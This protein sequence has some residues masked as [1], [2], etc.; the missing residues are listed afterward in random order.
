MA[1]SDTLDPYS[2]PNVPYQPFPVNPL[3]TGDIQKMQQSDIIKN[4]N[5]SL[6]ITSIVGGFIVLIIILIMWL[7]DKKLVNRV[8]LR[9]SGLISFVD[10]LSG[11]AAIAY[12]LYTT[13][14]TSI[15][16]FIG[17]AMSF[18]PT[19][20]LFLTV[21]IAFNLQ[22]VFLH[23]KKVSAFSDRWYLPVA[24]FG[25]FAINVPPL[26]Y[27]I[28]GYDYEGKEC[29]YRDPNGDATQMWK[30]ITFIIPVSLSMLY[31]TSVLIVVIMKLIFEHRKLADAVHTQKS[32]ATLTA[33][34]RRQKLLLL[35]L[36]S[37]ISLY[38]A[39]PLLNVSGIIVEYTW[40]SIHKTL[41]VPPPLV[42]WA[43]IGSCLPGLFNC[44]AFLFDPAIHNALRKVKKDLIENYGY[45]RHGLT[46]SQIS[47]PLSP[48][49][50]PTPTSPLFNPPPSPTFLRGP[51]RP[52]PTSPRS[53][54]MRILIP[55]YSPNRSAISPL[56]S[57][58]SPLRSQ[59]D[60]NV[61][62]TKM[63]PNRPILRWFVRAFLDKQKLPV[64]PNGLSI[65]S[66]SDRGHAYSS[67]SANSG[68]LSGQS[69]GHD[70]R[71]G[72]TRKYTYDIYNNASDK[73]RK[74]FMNRLSRVL[75]TPTE[76]SELD[77]SITTS[78]ETVVTSSDLTNS[79]DAET[80]TIVNPPKKSQCLKDKPRLVYE[81]SPDGSSSF[82]FPPVMGNTTINIHVHQYPSNTYVEAGPSRYLHHRRS[83]SN[84]STISRDSVDNEL[85][86]Y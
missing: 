21:M 1:S 38:A 55:P 80:K 12:T 70:Y 72:E 68:V 77:F 75:I 67:A 4:L 66:G 22:V 2:D 9:L 28:F 20:Y 65:S 35:K 11:A 63:N 48:S 47:P 17:W 32:N 10:I 19:L 49:F 57:A 44:L 24:F 8:S 79:F 52:I 85:S 3:Y 78:T 15:C 64:I 56:G 16:T 25:S 82:L 50:P 81:Q 62:R 37:R 23:R 13:G 36:V 69:Y 39:I 7:Y 83:N 14:D 40:L 58:F 60:P 74:K 76:E 46:H 51:N 59:F 42:Y 45:E 54:G 41:H 5:I 43:V 34:T 18:L 61:T 71:N 33:K 84:D 6:S 53:P 30:I 29:L 26:I 27:K 86:A 31:C 73:R